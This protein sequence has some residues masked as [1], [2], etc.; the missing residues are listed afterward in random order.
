[1]LLEECEPISVF[2]AHRG[3]DHAELTPIGEGG[4]PVQLEDVATGKTAYLVEVV[5]DGRVDGGEHLKTSNPP[6]TKH[7]PLPS[8]KGQV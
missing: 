7:R 1:M 4:G 5:V 6:E 3:S 2:V 8:S